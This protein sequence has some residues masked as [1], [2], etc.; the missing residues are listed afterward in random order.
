MW[1]LSPNDL[2]TLSRRDRG[3]LFNYF[4]ARA[5]A[6][7]FSKM[8]AVT[9]VGYF[10]M[11]LMQSLVSDALEAAADTP[12]WVLT[13]NEFAPIGLTVAAVLSVAYPLWRARAARLETAELAR[14]LERRELD[15]SRLTDDQ[16]FEKIVLPMVRNA[17]IPVA[18]D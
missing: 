13:F 4:G 1:Q 7:H 16:V 18:D 3:L 9:A 2:P 14:E 15:V 5:G 11:G 12:G 10:V 17:G 8:A 6:T